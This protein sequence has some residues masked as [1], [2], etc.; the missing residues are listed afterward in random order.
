M[1]KKQWLDHWWK[2]IDSCKHW[3]IKKQAERL[4]REPIETIELTG[5]EEKL[6][7]LGRTAELFNKQVTMKNNFKRFR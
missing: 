2:E 1:N 5:N 3:A 4:P 7:W 6:A